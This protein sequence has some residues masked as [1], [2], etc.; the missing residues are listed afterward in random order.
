MDSPQS[1]EYVGLKVS[2]VLGLMPS[3]T[4]LKQR[5]PDVVVGL[6]T[7]S[8][9]QIAHKITCISVCVCVCVF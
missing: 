5:D 3:C 8:I 4:C 2:I 6:L 7:I 1:I 9:Q